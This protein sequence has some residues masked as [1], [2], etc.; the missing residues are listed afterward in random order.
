VSV[1][2]TEVYTYKLLTKP[3]ILV[4]RGN[5]FIVAAAMFEAN[6]RALSDIDY[7]L[8]EWDSLKYITHNEG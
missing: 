1:T 2:I 4:I 3:N 6:D 7:R 5:S 8:R